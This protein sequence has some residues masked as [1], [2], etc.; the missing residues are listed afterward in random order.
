ML[1]PAIHE[2]KSWLIFLLMILIG[3]NFYFNFSFKLSLEERANSIDRSFGKLLLPVQNLISA[4]KNLAMDS[5]GNLNELAQA[6]EINQSLRSELNEQAL[7]LSHFEELRLENERLRAMVDFSEKFTRK[8]IPAR[9]I[10]SDPSA[11]F[12]T[13]IINRGSDHGVQ[14]G[15]AVI[16]LQGVVGKIFQVDSKRSR[17][18]LITDINSRLDAV[19]Q[20]SR[21]RVIVTGSVGGDLFLKYLPRRQNLN[22]NDVLVSSGM[23]GVFP[24]GVEI[25]KVG[26]IIKNPD[27]VLEE[28]AVISSVDFE[29]LEEVLVIQGRG[30]P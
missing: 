7:K 9:V 3:I 23:D 6:K 24:S 18:L 19:V 17:V 4:G 22:A 16:S 27:L 21:A 30:E 28:A 14:E 25:G 2:R 5:A 15:M 8:T 12:K 10:G 29:T 1:V 13:I 26:A 11:L 20:R